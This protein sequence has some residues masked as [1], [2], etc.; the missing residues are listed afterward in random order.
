VLRACVC[1]FFLC[2]CWDRMLLR[3]VTRN[4]SSS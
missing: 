1:L 2:L 3:A 4:F